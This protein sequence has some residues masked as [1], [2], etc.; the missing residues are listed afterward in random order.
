MVAALSPLNLP[1]HM[2]LIEVGIPTDGAPVFE[3]TEKGILLK[4]MLIGKDFHWQKSIEALLPGDVI[5]NDDPVFRIINRLPIETYLECVVGSEMNPEAP[6]EFLKAHA[7]ISRSWAI[8]KIIGVHSGQANLESS[9]CGSEPSACGSSWS[10]DGTD[11]SGANTQGKVFLPEKIINWEDT[12]DHH[13]FHVCSDDHCQRYQGIQPIRPEI[14]DA[15]RSTAD[16]VLLSPGGKLVDTRFSKCCGGRTEVFSSCW[17]DVEAPCLESFEDP[18]CDLTTLPEEKRDKV[19]SSILK[20]YD[21]ANGGG[22]RWHTTVSS[23]EIEENL[24]KKFGRD[25]GKVRDLEVTERGSS[26]RATRLKVYGTKDILEI[27]KELMI[28]RLLA[29]THLYSSA[30][31]I[32]RTS[33]QQKEGDIIFEI[34]GKGWGHGVGLCQ[35]GAARMALEGHHFR[36]ILSFYYP[37]STLSTFQAK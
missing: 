22:Y 26:G 21:L 7:V 34:E 1:S 3:A 15:I 8:G 35:I 31:T 27:G 14:L 11:F 10:R 37:S 4:N 18:W 12:C 17:Q 20:D 24:H 25:V 6:A 9:L 29:P 23:T 2:Q 19:L 28:R 36:S 33:N 13:G 16:M 5:V 30:I 32:N